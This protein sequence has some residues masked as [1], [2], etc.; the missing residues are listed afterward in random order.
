MEMTS[1]AE[2][3]KIGRLL[4]ELQGSCG[5]PTWTK[6][7]E[8]VH[9]IVQLYGGAL[10]T[11]LE[12]VPKEVERELFAD[13]LLSSLFL[14]HG[15]HPQSMEERVRIA[16]ARVEASLASRT[17]SVRLVFAT[18]EEIQLEVEFREGAEGRA[19]QGLESAIRRMIEEAAPEVQVVR[20]V[21]KNEA[22]ARM[23]L[24]RLGTPG[25]R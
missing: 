10:Q 13:E 16:L 7:E 14:L 5:P 24:V 8:L 25:D 21:D 2:G 11:V 23:G 1:H 17:R 6:V 12:K 3:E 20:I 9:R 18:S 19:R 4:E 15:M 22:M